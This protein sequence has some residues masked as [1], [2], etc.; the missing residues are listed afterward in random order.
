MEG[1]SKIDVFSFGVVI[2]N[3]AYDN[4]FPF[5]SKSDRFASTDKYFQ[6]MSER[7]LVLKEKNKRGQKRS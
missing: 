2:F 3:M 4:E 1:S 5:Y 6:A 7:K